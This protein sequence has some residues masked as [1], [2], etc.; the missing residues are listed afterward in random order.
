MEECLLYH[1]SFGVGHAQVDGGYDH[2]FALKS[3]PSTANPKY[4][5]LS[6]HVM[7]MSHRRLRIVVDQY[8]SC[9]CQWLV[10]YTH[11]GQHLR[12]A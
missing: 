6:G 12:M 2:N 10:Q 11:S 1:F 9:A 5:Y 7:L 4:V 3:T 8:V